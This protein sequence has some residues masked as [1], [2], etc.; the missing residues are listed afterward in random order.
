MALYDRLRLLYGPYYHRNIWR[1][2]TDRKRCH[3]DRSGLLTVYYDLISD[4]GFIIIEWGKP[5]DLCTVPYMNFQLRSTIR[6]ECVWNLLQKEIE[7]IKNK[8]NHQSNDFKKF[9]KALSYILN[10][11]VLTDFSPYSINDHL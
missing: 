1:R 9:E 6:G 7:K 2:N 11:A 8:F 4:S 10:N 3:F 5:A